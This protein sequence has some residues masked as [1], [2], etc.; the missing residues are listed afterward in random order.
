M[1]SIVVPFW[2]YNINHKKELQWGLWV[3]YP[4]QVAVEAWSKPEHSP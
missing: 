2:D 3:G 1:G 4:L